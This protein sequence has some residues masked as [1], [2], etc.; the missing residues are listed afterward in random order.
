LTGSI[1]NDFC[2][3]STACLR[4]R[5]HGRETVAEPNHRRAFV[6]S[7][8]IM[9][10]GFTIIPYITIFMQTNVGM[11]PEQIPLIYLC[12]GVATLV[13]ARW[14][15]RLADSLGKFETF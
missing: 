13:S 10:A 11:H 15:G 3:F 4:W 5:P 12:G 9:F 14:F 1:A 7:V 8:L 6:F 2:S